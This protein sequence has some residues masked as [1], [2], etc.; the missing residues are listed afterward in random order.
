MSRQFSLPI[1]VACNLRASELQDDC[2]QQAIGC[3][4]R[5]NSSRLEDIKELRNERESTEGETGRKENHREQM[6]YRIDIAHP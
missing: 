6:R 4:K 3:S 2:S 1:A 5:R